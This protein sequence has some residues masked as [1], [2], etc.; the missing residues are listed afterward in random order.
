MTPRSFL[1]LFRFLNSKPIK[2]IVKTI[3]I[4]T[5]LVRAVSKAIAVEVFKKKANGAD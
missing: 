1:P 4:A 2:Q 3:N 5:G